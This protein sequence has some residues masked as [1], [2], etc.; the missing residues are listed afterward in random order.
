MALGLHVATH[1]TE[2]HFRLTITRHE[3]WDDG[4]HGA[5]AAS[6]LIGVAG[7][8]DKARAAIL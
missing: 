2:R 8:R 1:H 7:C 6:D 5:L 4:V 3:G